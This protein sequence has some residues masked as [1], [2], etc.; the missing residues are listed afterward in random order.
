MAYDISLLHISTVVTQEILSYDTSLW[1]S[2]NERPF[3][4]LDIM[5]CNLFKAFCQPSVSVFTFKS[6]YLLI[7]ISN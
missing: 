6:K 5:S 1:R 2:F 3:F 7:S 4:I